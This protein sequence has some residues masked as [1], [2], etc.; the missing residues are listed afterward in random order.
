MSDR[1]PPTYTLPHKFP[2]TILV[3]VYSCQK[4]CSSNISIALSSSRAHHFCQFKGPNEK[5]SMQKIT[6]EPCPQKHSTLWCKDRPQLIPHQNHSLGGLAPTGSD[7]K[8][9]WECRG[10]KDRLRNIRMGRKG[11]LHNCL[12]DHGHCR[13]RDHYFQLE[14]EKHS[15]TL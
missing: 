6:H 2:Q 4:C 1:S 12:T 3:T 14:A 9:G 10:R 5:N 15:Y 11:V 7:R 8:L 13:T